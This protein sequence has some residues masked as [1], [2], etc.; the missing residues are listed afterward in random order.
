MSIVEIFYF[1]IG[2]CLGLVTGL[3]LGVVICLKR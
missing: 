3:V 1:F 2:S